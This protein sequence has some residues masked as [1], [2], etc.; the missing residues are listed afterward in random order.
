MERTK[1]IRNATIAKRNRGCRARKA[2]K[3]TSTRKRPIKLCYDKLDAWKRH[4]KGKGKVQNRKAF[5]QK[6]RILKKDEI[7]QVWMLKK[8]P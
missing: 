2:A 5:I 3:T 1:F 8:T 6:R 4:F 7:D